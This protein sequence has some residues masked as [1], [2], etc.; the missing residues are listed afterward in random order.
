MSRDADMRFVHCKCSLH[1]AHAGGV[2]R[3]A[4]LWW[5]SAGTGGREAAGGH[6]LRRGGSGKCKPPQIEVQIK[7]SP[8]LCVDRAGIAH[9]RHD[10]ALRRRSHQVLSV[11][12]FSPL[13]R[14][15]LNLPLC[16]TEILTSYTSVLSASAH[17]FRQMC[18][19]PGLSS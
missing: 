16:P 4:P 6:V 15:P 3:H 2:L 13:R 17:I 11:L 14:T 1:L 18:K 5:R 19:T 7:S 8:I 12:S 10:D 9:N